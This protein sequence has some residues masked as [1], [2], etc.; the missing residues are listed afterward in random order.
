MYV[1]IYRPGLCL[2]GEVICQIDRGESNHDPIDAPV[3]QRR[4]EQIAAKGLVRTQFQGKRP[5]QGPGRL[6]E[7]LCFQFKG[8]GVRLLVYY[9]KRQVATGRTNIDNAFSSWPA[10]GYPGDRGGGG[11]RTVVDSIYPTS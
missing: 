8:G 1:G 9:L 5:C 6:A 4:D 7:P 3:R 2:F 10:P 11:M